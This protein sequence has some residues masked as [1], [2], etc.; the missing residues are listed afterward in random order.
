M[1]LLKFGGTPFCG[2]AVG[3]SGE[4]LSVV[5]PLLFL[6]SAACFHVKQPLNS[7]TEIKYL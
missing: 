1:N 3:H 7:G 5:D 6:S 4:R 2:S